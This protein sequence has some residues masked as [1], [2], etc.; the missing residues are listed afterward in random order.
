MWTDEE[1]TALLEG[2]SRLITHLVV[3]ALCFVGH[4]AVYVVM[5]LHEASDGLQL[6]IERFDTEGLLWSI[7]KALQATNVCFTL[8]PCSRLA[9]K[10]WRSSSS[11]DSS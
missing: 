6:G 7:P 1:R 5:L 3:Q 11:M 10:N 8:M 9:K 2:L 4:V